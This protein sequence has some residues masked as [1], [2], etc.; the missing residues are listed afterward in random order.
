MDK[1][2]LDQMK[3]RVKILTEGRTP[4]STSESIG[5]AAIEAFPEI[6]SISAGTIADTILKSGYA[7]D[8]EAQ[9]MLLDIAIESIRATASA[10]IAT[11]S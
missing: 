11:Q 4:V 1:T 2:Q 5:G 8:R 10:A 6:V 9:E 7:T 3:N